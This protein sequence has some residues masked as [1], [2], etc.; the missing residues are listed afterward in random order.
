MTHNVANGQGALLKQD[1]R[2]MIF[3]EH[4]RGNRAGTVE[5]IDRQGD[6]MTVGVFRILEIDIG[7]QLG[8]S[9]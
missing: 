9:R 3:G 5:V 7:V 6:V 1:L 8:N 4:G 2:E